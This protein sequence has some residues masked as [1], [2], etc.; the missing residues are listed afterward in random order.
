[1][2][3]NN[4]NLM[5]TDNLLT[6]K[7]QSLKKKIFTLAKMEALVFADPK[8]SQ[9]YDEMAEN[10]EE[11]YGYHY[12]ETIMNMIFNDYV[13]NSPKYLQKYKMAIPKEKKRRDKSGINQLKKSGE[14]KMNKTNNDVDETTGAGGGGAGAFASALGYQEKVVETSTTGSVGGTGMPS[15]GYETPSAWGAGDL[16][17]GS[18]SPAITKPIWTGGKIIQESNYLVNPDGFAKYIDALNEDVNAGYMESNTNSDNT[19]NMITTRDQLKQMKAEGKKITPDIVPLLAGE[20]LHA[21]AIMLANK[22]LPISW[23]DLPDINSMWDYIDE[24]GGMTAKELNLAVKEAVDERLSEE[25]FEGMM[26]E[27]RKYAPN[28]NQHGFNGMDWE[29]DVWDKLENGYKMNNNDV[30]GLMTKEKD[31]ISQRH[32]EKG[33]PNAVADELWHKHSGGLNEQK[34]LNELS[35]H[36]AVE[37]VSDRQGEDPFMLGGIKWQF[38]NAKYPDGKIDIGVYRFG[39]DV[40]YD[41][42][43]WRESMNINETESSMIGDSQSGTMAFKG[44]PEGTV[45]AG[46]NVPTGMNNGGGLNEENPLFEELNKE[47]NAY[48][49]H[50]NKLMKMSEDKKPS[51]LVQVDRLGKEN[52]T[53]FKKDLGTSGTKEIIDVQKELEW[54]DQQT[55]VGDNPHKFSEDIEKDV[56]KRTK[57]VALKNVGNSTGNDG[58]E[59]P[60]RNLTTQEQDEVNEYRLGMNKLKYDRTSDKFEERMK[61]DMGDDLYKQ[62]KDY[63]KKTSEQP[64][65]NK[66]V[67]PVSEAMI[68]GRY[69]DDLNKS[70]IVDFDLSEV[71]L[72]ESVDNM[73]PIDFTGL[74]NSYRGRTEDYKVK[75]NETVVNAINSHKF[76]TD[77]TKIFAVSASKVIN[78]NKGKN[79]QVVNEQFNK[80]KHL[81]GYEPH[82][83]INTS[84]TK[85]NRGF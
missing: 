73:F 58:K 64:M 52:Q 7:E 27:D 6:E 11:R 43:A 32:R 63:L 60:K 81:L 65:Y 16:I 21:V 2:I 56:L 4:V 46:G 57:G 17:K 84:E 40:V 69:Y 30:T 77:G 23:D 1:M 83:Y 44:Q 59:I 20:A 12:N 76:F 48:S 5:E 15:G 8:L 85:K 72:R 66:D 51:S 26:D 75:I 10:G 68:T 3:Q 70:H 79:K 9:V 37:Y 62:G 54:L 18:K 82:G 61:E 22:M 34:P 42:A 33:D 13:L 71:I 47:L 24:N 80:M 29:A 39:H 41:Y 55:N 67:Q 50:H 53:N 35:L 25:G 36:D 49:I 19:G 74:G 38:V 31:F 78:E 14:E 28:P 45:S